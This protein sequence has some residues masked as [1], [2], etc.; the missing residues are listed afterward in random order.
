MGKNTY[1]FKK[2]LT[3]LLLILLFIFIIAVGLGRYYIS[4]I[5]VL[6][7]ITSKFIPINIAWTTQEEAIIFN[8]RIP[9]IIV[10]MLVGMALSISGASYQSVFKNPLVAPD[11]LGVSSGACV[12]AAMAILLNF[13]GNTVQ[14]MAFSGGIL[15]VIM[16]SIITK[17]IKN[18]STVTLIFAGII[19]SG[20]MNSIL[21]L[22]K[23]IADA[24]TQLA[25]ITYWQLGSFSTV[26]WSDVMSIAF[27]V[28]ITVSVL[29]GLSWRINIL[30]LG[31]NEA[32]TLGADI[33]KLRGV[34]VVCSTILTSTSICVCGTISWVGLIIPHLGRM[35]VGADNQKAIPVSGLIGAGFLLFI[36]TLARLTTSAEL[37]VSILTGLFGT[38]FYLYLLLKHRTRLI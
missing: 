21:G 28:A 11:M 3:I 27:P 36:D 33:V 30:S 25:S 5:Q 18:N 24:D 23:Y 32:R 14:I 16:V 26:V 22:L 9:R 1:D 8:L 6:K 31:D 10:S 29:I 4:P 35:L 19:I 7:I 2:V 38:P 34:I 12:G 15:A 37:P 20:L 13:N 17:V